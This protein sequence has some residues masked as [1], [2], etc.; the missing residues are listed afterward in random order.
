MLVSIIYS[1]NNS[2]AEKEATE[3]QIQVSL[4]PNGDSEL[5]LLMRAMYEEADEVKK[6]IAAGEPIE[7]TLDHEKILTAHA[8]EPDKAASVEF[9]AF[10]KAYLQAVNTLKTASPEKQTLHFESMVENCMACHQP[11]CPGPIV[12]IKKLNKPVKKLSTEI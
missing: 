6:Q 12:K 9:K 7:F 11:L 8:T 3:K 10:A 1:C 4:N 2:P 5:A